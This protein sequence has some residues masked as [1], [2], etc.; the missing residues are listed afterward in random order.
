M[1]NDQCYVLHENSLVLPESVSISFPS[2][3]QKVVKF[4]KLNSDI[5]F[6]PD[7]S[8]NGKKRAKK[9]R[10]LPQKMVF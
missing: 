8:E 2:E 5:K 3:S 10:I 6:K 1:Y 9:S 4:S 7:R